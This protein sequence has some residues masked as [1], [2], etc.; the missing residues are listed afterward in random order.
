L[1]VVKGSRGVYDSAMG[2]YGTNLSLTALS[3]AEL[4]DDARLTAAR[5]SFPGWQIIEVFGGYLAIQADSVIV[6]AIDL[7][8]LVGKLRKQESK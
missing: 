3:A 8:G 5:E 1:R 2:P 7:D 4:A 6:Q